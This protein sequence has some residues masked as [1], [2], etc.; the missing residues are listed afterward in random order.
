MCGI[1][2]EFMSGNNASGDGIRIGFGKF[3]IK[4]IYAIE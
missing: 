1:C 2:G 4:I 3:F